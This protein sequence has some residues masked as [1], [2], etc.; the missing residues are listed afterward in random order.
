MSGFVD[1]PLLHTLNGLP[2]DR[3]VTAGGLGH[4]LLKAHSAI[5]TAW[6]IRAAHG[7]ELPYTR[8]QIGAGPESRLAV[9]VLVVDRV[10]RP[11]RRFACSSGIFWFGDC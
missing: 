4:V 2:I 10:A 6:M 7:A 8:P 9:A 5:R 3:N 11:G 1:Q